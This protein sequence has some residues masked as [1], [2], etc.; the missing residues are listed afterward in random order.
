MKI[1]DRLGVANLSRKNHIAFFVKR[2]T[3]RQT[4]VMCK[5]NLK[6]KTTTLSGNVR[7]LAN[8]DGEKRVPQALFRS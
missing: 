7:S 3:K 8:S 6:V 2:L 1:L 5:N 4:P